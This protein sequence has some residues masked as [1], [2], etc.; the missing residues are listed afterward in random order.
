MEGKDGNSFDTTNMFICFE[1]WVRY[2]SPCHKRRRPRW[3]IRLGVSL[4]FSSGIKFWA[5]S[6]RN[7][8]RHRSGQSWSHCIW[9]SLWLI[10]NFQS[11][12]STHSRWWSQRPSWSNLR[13]STKSL[14]IWRTLKCILRMKIKLYFFCVLYRDHLNLSRIPCSM[15]KKALS[16]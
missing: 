11:N 6:R 10:D 12:N 2:R 9:S 4:S 15:T 7:Q 1:G 13:S 5:M 8:R 3:W 14:M 16:P